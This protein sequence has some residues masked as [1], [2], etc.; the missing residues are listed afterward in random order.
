M[1]LSGHVLRLI[2]NTTLPKPVPTIVDG[3]VP[4]LLPATSYGFIVV[5]D[6]N[7][8]ACQNE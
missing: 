4:V 7:A 8:P 6:A 5:P 3:G 1:S 2:D